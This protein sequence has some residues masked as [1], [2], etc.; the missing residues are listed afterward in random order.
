MTSSNLLGGK[1]NRFYTNVAKE[2][3][4]VN[5]PSKGSYTLRSSWM[6]VFEDA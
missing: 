1:F 5:T 3:G 4:W 2:S 6:E